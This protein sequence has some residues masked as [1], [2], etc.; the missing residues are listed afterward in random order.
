MVV[1]RKKSLVFVLKIPTEIFCKFGNFFGSYFVESIGCFLRRF[2]LNVMPFCLGNIVRNFFGDYFG[3]AFVI[4]YFQNF[5]IFA[6]RFL[7]NFSQSSTWDLPWSYFRNSFPLS[8]VD[9]FQDFSRSFARFCPEVLPAFFFRN[10]LLNIFY[11]L[12]KVLVGFFD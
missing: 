2:F 10:F 1:S 8:L 11:E 7:Q 12:R 4:S 3:R 9:L 5:P 6:R